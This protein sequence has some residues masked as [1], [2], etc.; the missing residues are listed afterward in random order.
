MPSH[1][2]PFSEDSVW[3]RNA[4]QIAPITASETILT[5]LLAILLLKERRNMVQ[6]ISDAVIVVMGVLLLF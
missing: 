6:K 3:H 2:I 4:S 1:Y 5:V